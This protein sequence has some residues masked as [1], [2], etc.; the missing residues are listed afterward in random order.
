M[1]AYSRYFYGALAGFR[2]IDFAKREMTALRR[3]DSIALL[4]RLL[5]IMQR[6]FC[7]FRAVDTPPVS[8]HGYE[9]Q[10]KITFKPIYPSKQKQELVGENSKSP[11]LRG[12]QATIV[13]IDG[14]QVRSG[15]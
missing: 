8:L 4:G 5:L 7:P 13:G 15:E 11:D 2:A 9:T 14:M 3:A 6:G 10:N 12:T 1:N